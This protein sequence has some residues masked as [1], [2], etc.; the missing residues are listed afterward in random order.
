MRRS[1]YLFK[2]YDRINLK[3]ITNILLG[4]LIS[5]QTFLIIVTFTDILSL[6][7]MKDKNIIIE[8]GIVLVFIFIVL[9]LTFFTYILDNMNKITEYTK[10]LASEKLNIDD[11]IIKGNSDFSVIAKAIND[12]KAN[13]IFFIDNTKNNILVLSDSIENLSKSMNVTYE[14]NE[15]IAINMEEISCKS[16]DQFNLVKESVLKASEVNKSIDFISEH[17]KDV[18]AISFDTNSASLYGRETLNIYNESIK[19]ISQSV[20]EAHE[21]IYK[22][23][24]SVQEIESVVR[25]IVGLSEQLKMLSLNASIEANR[26]GEVGRGFTVVA[27]EITKLSDNTNS[28]INKINNIVRNILNNSYDVEVSIKNSIENSEKGNKIFSNIEEVFNE[29]NEKNNMLL[30]ETNEI[31]IEM[32]NINSNTKSNVILSEK[33]KEISFHVSQSTEN[34]VAVIQEQLAEFQEINGSMSMLQ[35]LLIKIE[36]LTTRFELDIKPVEENPGKLLKILVI[37]PYVDEVWDMIRLGALY[38]KKVLKT[39][40][41]IVEIIPVK[42][43]LNEGIS[44]TVKV[45]ADLVKNEC[46][47]MIIPGFLEDALKSVIKMN[48]PIVAFNDDIKEKNNRIAYVGQNSYES[49]NVAAKIMVEQIGSKGSL[50]IITAEEA[51]ES[52]ELRKEGFIDCIEKKKNIEVIDILKVSLD[53]EKSYQMIKQYLENHNN[54]SGIFCAAVNVEGLARAIEEC[55]M[56]SKIKTIVYDI[57]KD[58]LQYINKGV[59]TCAIGQDLFRQGYDSLICLYNYLVTGEKLDSEK[60]WTKIEIID[61]NNVKHFLE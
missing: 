16:Q 18:K 19:S 15:Q 25:F 39:K 54:I 13:I 44:N 24:Q 46:D 48:I 56:S 51:Y 43:A 55:Q 49:G 3:V 40:K 28:G 1:L 59:I 47:G 26:A 7:D 45:V 34:S 36:N 6:F 27:N 35:S 57:T 41:A 38:G 23:R 21:F 58:I 37:M 9:V 52:I 11:L 33:V 14:G 4:G 8:I 29:I 53:N 20:T 10:T 42:L 2:I 5:I 12:I 22:L 32:S 61:A 17:I 30:K 31:I 50:V 60:T